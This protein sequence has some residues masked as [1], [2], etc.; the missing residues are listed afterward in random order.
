MYKWKKI[1]KM[2]GIIEES[3]TNKIQEKEER[4]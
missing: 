4:L 3:N 1:G 2:S